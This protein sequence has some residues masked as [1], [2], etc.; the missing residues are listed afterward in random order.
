MESA[1][2]GQKRY[3]Y[4][5]TAVLATFTLAPKSKAPRHERIQWK[6]RNRADRCGRA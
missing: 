1:I 6:E 5:N 4:P 3:H 2:W